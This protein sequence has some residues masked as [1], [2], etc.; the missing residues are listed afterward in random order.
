MYTSVGRGLQPKNY[1]TKGNFQFTPGEVRSSCHE[2][3]M[4][5][6]N[7]PMFLVCVMMLGAGI[8]LFLPRVNEII[9]MMV[10]TF[11]IAYQVVTEGMVEGLCVCVKGKMDRIGSIVS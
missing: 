6:N 9:G 1:Q 5:S 8:K 4:S 10:E 3:L 7:L 11:E 2:Y